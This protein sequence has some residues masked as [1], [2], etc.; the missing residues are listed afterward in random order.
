MGKANT[1]GRSPRTH[2]ASAN[3]SPANGQAFLAIKP[4]RLLAVD[5]H[6]FTPQQD[7]KAPIAEPATLVRKFAQ[8]LPQGAIIA[9]PGTITH[10]LAIGIKD[11]ARPPLAHPM[12]LH[13]SKRTAS[14]VLR[15]S[16]SALM[17]LR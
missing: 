5:H 15:H 7:V 17:D 8:A 16:G 12:V 10:A 6:A 1:G 14:R 11:T 13:Q 3:T 2:G 9:P 4:L